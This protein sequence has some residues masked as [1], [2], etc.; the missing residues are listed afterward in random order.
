MLLTNKDHCK[1]CIEECSLSVSSFGVPFLPE[2]P[3]V[4]V[5]QTGR[6][7]VSS[8]VAGGGLDAVQETDRNSWIY[9]AES[10]ATMVS[11]ELEIVM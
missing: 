9:W 7:S 6:R 4:F 5:G 10:Q 2:P 3:G 1:G 11:W 8:E